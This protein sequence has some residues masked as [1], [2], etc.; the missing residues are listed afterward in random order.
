MVVFSCS[1]GHQAWAKQN[2]LTSSQ[3]PFNI[4]INT[5]PDKLSDTVVLHSPLPVL[6]GLQAT[7]SFEL[8]QGYLG[9]KCKYINIMQYMYACITVNLKWLTWQF[10][11]IT[12]AAACLTHSDVPLCVCTP[13]ACFK[14]HHVDRDTSTTRIT[15]DFVHYYASTT[16][17]WEAACPQFFGSAD[18]CHGCMDQHQT[19]SKW[20]L[21][22]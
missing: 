7:L 5:H 6:S 17:S 19:C 20:R 1:I 8:L 13:N 16:L 11:V 3:V 4:P 14:N 10:A 18:L 15:G 21:C 2:P 9:Y 12:N 22:L